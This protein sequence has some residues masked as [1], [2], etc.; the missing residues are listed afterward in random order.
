MNVL[1]LVRDNVRA[2]KP[3][4]SARDDFKKRSKNYIYLIAKESPFNN[5][6]NRYP[7]PQQLDLK[8][9]LSIQ[10]EVSVAQILL[11]NGSDE[12]LDL[13]F[14]AF[15]NP[16]KDNV[17]ILP[18]TY[19]MYEVLANI[20][21]VE[22]K[23]VNLLPGFELDVDAILNATSVDSKLLFICSPNNPSGN[24]LNEAAIENLLLKFNGIVVI[25]EAYIEFSQ[26]KS[27]LNRLNEF[28]NLVI[29]Q[30]FSKAYGMAGV[31]LGSCYASEEIITILNK[32]KPPYNINSLT[33]ETVLKYLS[34]S[35]LANQ[36]VTKILSEKNTLIKL[37]NKV[38]F[39]KKLHPSDANF[40]LVQV[41]DANKRYH[42]LVNKGIITRNRSYH[43]LCENCLRITVGSAE[44]NNQLIKTLNNI[45]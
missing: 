14:R 9:M 41:D 15:C 12:V 3:Y 20:N 31:R 24:I 10:K 44:E 39:I 23:K 6:V 45:K 1:D 34:K 32:I 36:H 4:A 8:S 30:T 37:L 27:W 18:P 21:D 7:D 35:S 25:D 26:H 19:G 38:P 40:I 2:L 11:G 28:P 17:I 16:N 33:Q 13:I 43:Y 5:G 22:V 42:Q 29:T